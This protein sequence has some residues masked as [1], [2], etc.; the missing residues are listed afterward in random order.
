MAF[1]LSHYSC[2]LCV[3]ML[4]PLL[5][6]CQDTFK[7]SRAAYYGS[8]DGLGTPTGA[9]GFGEYGRNVNGGQVGAVSG[10]YRYGTGCGAC[11][12]VK[13]KIPNLC[14][15]DGMRVVVTDHGGGGNTDFILSPQGF[16]KLALP[17]MAKD[18]F[19][20]GVVGIE[21]RRV[22]CQYPNSNLLFKVHEHSQFPHYLALVMLYQAGLSDITAV[23]IWQ[24]DL[25]EWTGMR[26]SY[27]AVWDMP[28][29]PKGGL[30]LRFQVSGRGGGQKWVLL[31]DLIPA[32]WKPGFSYDSAFQLDD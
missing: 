8:P 13:C 9:C 12:Q 14:T 31:R 5:C 1:S 6:K 29:P 17:N 19:A 4:L 18:L 32:D 20:Y 26:K 2:F 15:E 23:E 11:Y 28:N 7:S 22:P 27:G 25:Q 16:S 30:N 21:Y 24:E 3:I 10:L